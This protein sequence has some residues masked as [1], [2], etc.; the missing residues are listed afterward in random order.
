MENV[1]AYID[2]FNLYYGMMDAGFGRY[3]WLNIQGLVQSLLKPAQKLLQVNYFT[4][5][6]IN[7]LEGRLRQRAFLEALKTQE[8]V[9]VFFGKF[10]KQKYNCLHCGNEFQRK[11]E[12]MTDTA[13]VTE[14]V[15]DYYENKF[16][17]AMII[18]GD[19][20]LLPPMRLINEAPDNKR[21]LVAFPPARVNEEM[22]LFAKGSM[23]IGR[24]KLADNQF[25][26]IFTGVDRQEISKPEGWGQVQPNTSD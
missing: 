13:I 12:K 1:I 10:Q 18:S 22:R 16:D 2:G 23:V 5:M 8:L 25:P 14:L 15:K 11:C 3:R 17:A 24:K 26:A 6:V 19:T 21:V 9:K 20:D 7:D 4:T